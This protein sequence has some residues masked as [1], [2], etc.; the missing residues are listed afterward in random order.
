[1]DQATETDLGSMFDQN[2]S[3]FLPSCAAKNWRFSQKPIKFLHKKT[4]FSRTNKY[5]FK[6]CPWVARGFFRRVSVP[7]GKTKCPA[8]VVQA[9]QMVYFRTKNTILGKIRRALEWKT[10]CIFNDHWDYF[11]AIWYNKWPFGIS[12]G[13]LVY[14]FRV[15]V[16]LHQEKSGNPAVVWAQCLWLAPFLKKLPSDVFEKK[17]PMDFKNCPKCSPTHFVSTFLR[18]IPQQILANLTN[19][20]KMYKEKIVRPISSSWICTNSRLE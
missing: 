14:F 5:P 12:N 1:M 2:F 3:I 7:T 10:L 17:R 6:N 9:C 16:C 11:T 15:L 19:F 4:F 13:H 8:P 18:K 20:Q